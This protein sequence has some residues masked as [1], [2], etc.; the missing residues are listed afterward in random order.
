MKLYVRRLYIVHPQTVHC[1]SADCTLYVRRLYIV[2]PQTV[3]F[4]LTDLSFINAVMFVELSNIF[5][6]VN[7]YIYREEMFTE[8]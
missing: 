4:R 2:C 6:I 8:L 3:H 5:S 1:T 7:L